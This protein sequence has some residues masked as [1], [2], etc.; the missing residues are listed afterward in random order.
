M[1]LVF[2]TLMGVCL[3]LAWVRGSWRYVAATAVLIGLAAAFVVVND[4]WYGHGWGADGVTMNPV[5]G[6]AMLAS[7]AAGVLRQRR[8]R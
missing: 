1:F 6:G 8:G 7:A 2:A 4:G 3:I 5:V